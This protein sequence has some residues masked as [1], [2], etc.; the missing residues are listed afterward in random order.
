MV[1]IDEVGIVLGAPRV[2]V[3]ELTSPATYL[4]GRIAQ[5]EGGVLIA[6]HFGSGTYQ[7][8]AKISTS[9]TSPPG[10]AKGE[11][12]ISEA[13]LRFAGP[14]LQINDFPTSP[15][16]NQLYYRADLR[17]WFMWSGSDWVPARYHFGAKVARTASQTI[18]A[19]TTFDAIA[20][21]AA[22]I[23]DQPPPGAA[24]F[25]NP[26]TNNTRLVLPLTGK[27]RLHAKVEWAANTSTGVAMR[28]I[29]QMRYNGGGGTNADQR[30]FITGAANVDC[31]HDAVWQFEG[32]AGHYVE[33]Y[34][35]QSTTGTLNIN[36]AE[37]TIEYLG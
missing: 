3:P 27:Y 6:P 7:P 22:D 13:G 24:E 25:H 18:S 30:T 29:L 16:T 11:F 1:Q 14:A 17:Q 10:N 35:A 37:A 28:R 5:S 15:V 21:S 4:A 31:H 20:F 19:S 34:A 32:T 23:W 12:V 8:F 2:L 9:P 36:A 26:S 33:V